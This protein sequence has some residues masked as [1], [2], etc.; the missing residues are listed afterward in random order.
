MNFIVHACM[1]FSKVPTYLLGIVLSIWSV[2]SKN[3]FKETYSVEKNEQS[4]KRETSWSKFF[5]APLVWV[6]LSDILDEKNSFI[7]SHF[8]FDFRMHC[9]THR[10]SYLDVFFFSVLATTWS[11][12]VVVCLEPATVIGI[13]WPF[14]T[15]R[16]TLSLT[17]LQK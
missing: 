13:R 2:I 5:H 6:L 9:W 7:L 12:S 15:V 10:F 3:S 16:S 8:L 4:L 14:S 17:L 1:S 11:F